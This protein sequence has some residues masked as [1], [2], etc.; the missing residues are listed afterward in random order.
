MITVFN[1]CKG[2]ASSEII[3]SFMCTILL[4]NDGQSNKTKRVVEM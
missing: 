3:F 1:I 2:E 4:P